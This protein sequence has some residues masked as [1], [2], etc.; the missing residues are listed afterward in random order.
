[1]KEKV[2]RDNREKTNSH[3]LSPQGRRRDDTEARLIGRHNDISMF[4]SALNATSRTVFLGH[5][6]DSAINMI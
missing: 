3:P 5:T 1:M 6:A 4:M 2:R